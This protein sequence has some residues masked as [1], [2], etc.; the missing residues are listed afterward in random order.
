MS[1]PIAVSV[2][3]PGIAQLS[4]P[5]PPCVQTDGWP[6]HVY[7]VSTAQIALQPS[8]AVVLPS[9]QCSLPSMMPLPHVPPSVWHV[10]SQPSP[11]IVLPS[12]HV[13]VL[14]STTPLPHV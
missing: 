14:T 9:S 2:T 10:A 11:L 1:V 13:S 12:S 7:P 6:V 4:A 5:L 8:D 3:V